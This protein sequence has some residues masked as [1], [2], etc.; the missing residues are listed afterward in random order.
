MANADS[1]FGL[2]P[3][4]YVSGAPY[5]GAANVY[6]V[7]DTENNLGVGSVVSL[8]GAG[9]NGV[10]QVQRATVSETPANN[11][12]IVGVIVGVVDSADGTVYRENNRYIAASTNAPGFALVADDPNLLFKMQE[13][14]VGSTLSDASLGGHVNITFGTF[15]TVYGQARDEIDSSTFSAADTQNA[16]NLKILRL[17]QEQASNSV[18]TNAV[19]ECMIVNHALRPGGRPTSA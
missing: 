16:Y 8:N 14:S 4:R 10:A 7:L 12:P 1:P 13:D 2:I 18:G 11:T 19:W 3:I 6:S 15:D 17:F 5:N 9:V